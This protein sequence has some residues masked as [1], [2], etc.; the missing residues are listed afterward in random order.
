MFSEGSTFAVAIAIRDTT[1]L[2]DSMEHEFS[3]EESRENY[4]KAVDFVVCKL[5]EFS[6]R[7]ME[8]FLGVA[9]PHRVSV[10]CPSLC[11]RLWAEL[12]IV[13]LALPEQSWEH[14]KGSPSYPRWLMRSL[15]EQAESMGRKCVR[16]VLLGFLPR[17]PALNAAGN[18][19]REGSHCSKLASLAS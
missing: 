17:S 6:E 1:Y 8:K 7:H 15:D 19:A 11:P 3:P 5:R 12:D 16:C 9:M 10:K 4:S 18:L 14:G 13:P 2:L